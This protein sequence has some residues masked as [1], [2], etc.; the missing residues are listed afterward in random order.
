[1]S[2]CVI[3]LFTHLLFN[4]SVPIVKLPPCGD[5]YEV[6]NIAKGFPT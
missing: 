4:E 6:V 2:I 3:A 1:M 5:L